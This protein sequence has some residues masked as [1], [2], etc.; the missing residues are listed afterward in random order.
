MRSFFMKLRKRCVR[1]ALHGSEELLI[2]IVTQL[3][4]DRGKQ[5]AEVGGV[6]RG[7][8]RDIPLVQ[9]V[10]VVLVAQQSQHVLV[11]RVVDVLLA[12]LHQVVHLRKAVHGR[13]AHQHQLPVV[14]VL[15][16][17]LSYVAIVG[18]MDEGS[19]HDADDHGHEEDP[20][21]EQ[22]HDHDDIS[23]GV[24]V[25]GDKGLPASESP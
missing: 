23:V 15:R 3:V 5:G 19:V 8:H 18:N 6:F 17:D 24:F 11:P 2:L 4:E 1:A 13:V 14:Q 21:E 12:V 7:E 9:L 22:E 10:D 16:L 20:E 25:C